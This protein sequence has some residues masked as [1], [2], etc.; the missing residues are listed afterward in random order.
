MASRQI[1]KT[2]GI[3]SVL[4]VCTLSGGADARTWVRADQ[5]YQVKGCSVTVFTNPEF[6]GA[7]WTTKNGWAVVGWEFND[8]IESV[9]VHSGIWQ[10]FKDDNF[11]EQIESLYPGNYAHLRPSSSNVFS[12]FKCVRAT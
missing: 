6:A 8:S 2:I 4:S 1:S 12:S 7:S 10:F 9:K 3:L 5:Q 11:K